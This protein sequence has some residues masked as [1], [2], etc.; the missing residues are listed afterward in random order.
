[1]SL[2]ENRELVRRFNEEVWGKGRLDLIDELFSPDFVDHYQAPGGPPGRDGIKYDVQR[3]RAAFPDLEIRTEDILC[4]GDRAALRWS[5]Q[6]T[7]QGGFPGI[8]AT[9]ISVTMSGMHFYRIRECRIVER[10]DEFDG[11]S[12][13]RQLGAA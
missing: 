13:M 3:V 8:S 10:W 12:V 5:G 1:M 2:D 9:G 11:T 6:G 7:Y 4:E